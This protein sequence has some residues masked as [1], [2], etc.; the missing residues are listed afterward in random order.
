MLCPFEHFDVTMFFELY[1]EAKRCATSHDQPLIIVGGTGFYLKAMMEGLSTR[2]EI[3]L[4][5]KEEVA[6]LLYDLPKAYA[7]MYEKDAVYAS[8]VASNDTYRIE[9]WLEL[10]IATRTTPSKYLLEAK[11]EPI[12]SNLPLFEIETPKEILIQ[13]VKERTHGMLKQGL[14]DEIFGLEKSYT[15]APQCMKAIGIKEVLDYFDGLYTYALLEEK[16]ATHTLQLAKRQR[17]FNASQFPP[18][19]KMERLSLQ[20]EIENVL[21]EF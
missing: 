14:I 16:I 15:R 5:V 2:P 11:Q 13:R 19:P 20:K 1:H 7:L 3:T 17:T 18:H 10:F 21:K 9:K 4:H 8:K 6:H 12:L